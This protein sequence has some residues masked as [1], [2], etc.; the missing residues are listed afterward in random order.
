[1]SSS[2]I[3][4]KEELYVSSRP[5]EEFKYDDPPTYDNGRIPKWARGPS[6]RERRRSATLR[7]LGIVFGSIILGM[8]FIGLSG[9]M[10]GSDGFAWLRNKLIPWIHHLKKHHS[11]GN[12]GHEQIHHFNSFTGT[13]ISNAHSC[14]AAKTPLSCHLKNGLSDVDSCCVNIPGGQLLIAQFWDFAPALGPEN[15]WTLHGLWPDNCDGSYEQFCDPSRSVSS[16]EAVLSASADT[17]DLVSHMHQIWKSSN[18]ND[19][20]L[21]THEWNK[22]GTCIS[23]LEPKCYGSYDNSSQAI[24]EYFSRAVQLNSELDTFEALASAGISPNWER[25]WSKIQ[26]LEALGE[27]L[28][29]GHNVTLGCTRGNVLNEVWY[30]FNVQGRTQD[31]EFIPTDPDG[32]KGSC[33]ETGIKYLPKVYKGVPHKPSQPPKYPWKPFTG[34]GHILVDDG[35]EGCLISQGDWYASGTC[36]TFR[37]EQLS[38]GDVR[39]RSSRGDCGVNNQGRFVCG[40]KVIPT[41]FSVSDDGELVFDGSPVWKAQQKAVAW[42]KEG[43]YSGVSESDDQLPLSVEFKLTWEGF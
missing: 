23:T 31:G 43:I 25:S 32:F 42:N 24:V 18:G 7:I 22:H 33:P 30:H 38:T 2:W 40:S 13:R 12:S 19:D 6:A 10:N 27:S 37:T 34:H 11:G 3:N 14:P 41:T 20:H 4:E 28:A 9:I 36:A 39:L 29:D 35:T 21:W 1:M 26:I 17:V 15:K 16:I 8:F 5:A